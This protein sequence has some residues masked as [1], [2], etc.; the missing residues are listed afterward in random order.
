[1]GY[2]PTLYRKVTLLVKAGIERDFFDDGDRMERLDVLFADRYL[3][4]F[5]A[6]Q[7]GKTVTLSWQLAF[8]AAPHWQPTVLQHLLLGMNAHILLD[9]GIAA[10]ETVSSDRLHDLKD[11]FDRINIIL[12]SQINDIQNELS[13][14]WPLFKPLDIAAGKVDELLARFSIN[15][16]RDQAWQVANAI[17]ALDSE[18]IPKAI[19]TLDRRVYRLGK[20]IRSP[21]LLIRFWLLIVRMGELRSP[22]RI[23]NILK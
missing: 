20:L 12:S 13:Q 22:R 3:D 18:R 15:R 1:L 9:L 21:G 11:D 19:Q 2:F 6:Y 14:I 4:A 8:D 7:G 5:N 16:T 23:I 10:A 17:S